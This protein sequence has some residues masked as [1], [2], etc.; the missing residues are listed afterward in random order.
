ML[1]KL[2][3]CNNVTFGPGEASPVVCPANTTQ[4]SVSNITVPTGA[5]TTFVPTIGQAVNGWIYRGCGSELASGRAMT[6]A[7]YTDSSNMTNSAC[8]HFCAAKGFQL[9]GTEFGTQ[10]FCDSTLS[11]ATLF[12]LN[13]SCSSASMICAGNSSEICGGK[14][15]AKSGRL[16]CPY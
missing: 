8:Q 3:G 15:K 10:C 14:L 11:L 9:A 4:P 5:V 7:T 13:Q 12:S 1:S 6:G 16:I 2:P